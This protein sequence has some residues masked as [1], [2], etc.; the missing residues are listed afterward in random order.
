MALYTCVHRR[1]RDKGNP[2]DSEPVELLLLGLERE[3]FAV[4][5]R[6]TRTAL[7]AHRVPGPALPDD[8][9]KQKQQ[10]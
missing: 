7:C 1:R 4:A 8:N 5:S 10:K 3:S 9:A 6:G 2:K